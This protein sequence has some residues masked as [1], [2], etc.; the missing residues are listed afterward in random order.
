MG[1]RERSALRDELQVMR[2]T[3]ALDGGASA[4]PSA[5]VV[6]ADGAPHTCTRPMR[7]IASVRRTTISQASGLKLLW[8]R[9]E[10]NNPQPPV[11][12]SRDA[13][14]RSRS[15]TLDRASAAPLGGKCC[16]R[17]TEREIT[18]DRDE[19][20]LYELQELG[21]RSCLLRVPAANYRTTNDTRP[22]MTVSASL[23]KDDE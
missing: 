7:A 1:S 16:K 20:S 14:V 6:G 8:P 17:P 9:S 18:R 10:R 11:S 13:S 4:P 3:R 23:A 19:L 2:L 15:R 12:R 5:A 22:G 21:Y